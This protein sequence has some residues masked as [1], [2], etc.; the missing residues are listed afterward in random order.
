MVEEWRSIVAAVSSPVRPHLERCLQEH[1]RY[2]DALADGFR[3]RA[4]VLTDLQRRLNAA[5]ERVFSAGTGVVPVEVTTLERAWLAA[6]RA[7]GP[8]RELETLWRKVAPERWID[9]G[10][11]AP[12]TAEAIVTLASD[13]DGVEEAER[14]ASTLREALVPWGVTV[15]PHTEWIVSPEIMFVVRAEQLFAIAVGSIADVPHETTQRAHRLR[16]EVRAQLGDRRIEARNS[17]LGREL[18]WLAFASSVWRDTR[19]EAAP[20]EP[21]LTIYRRGYIPTAVDAIGITLTAVGM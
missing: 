6:S 15:G 20:F 18:G 17:S 5:R 9:S 4:A 14:A 7:P 16:H 12:A 2:A 13:P 3:D 11:R 21:F 19:A 10:R 1:R 8:T